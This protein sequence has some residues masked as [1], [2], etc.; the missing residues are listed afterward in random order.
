M[1][2]SIAGLLN[3]APGMV[4]INATTGEDLTAFGRG[5]GVQA[6]AI[7]SLVVQTRESSET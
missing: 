2:A 6:F 4:G 5:E 3:I 1:K 7:V